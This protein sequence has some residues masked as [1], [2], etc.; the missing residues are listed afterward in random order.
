MS[1]GVLPDGMVAYATY[2]LSIKLLQLTA[3]QRAAIDEIVRRHYLEGESM[4]A[5]F[6]G[7]NKVCAEVTYYKTKGGWSHNP[8]FVAALEEAARLALRRKA[9]EAAQKLGAA[10]D[11]A[12][13][14]ADEAV[15][16]WVDVFKYADDHK[17]RN[18]AAQR[19]IDLAFASQK[20]KSEPATSE[21]SDWWAAL[22][23]GDDE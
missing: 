16:A 1:Y 20:G 18:D 7:A 19:L 22:E 2:E 14:S 4:A 12:V 23:D 15:K 5:L 10:T 11:R 17:A 9:T 6:R 13:N 8:D 21:E 3:K